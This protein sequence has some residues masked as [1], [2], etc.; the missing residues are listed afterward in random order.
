MVFIITGNLKC[1]FMSF[2]FF[3]LV[4]SLQLYQGLCSS[5]TSFVLRLTLPVAFGLRSIQGKSF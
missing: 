4:V 2:D 1:V 3:N 5:E